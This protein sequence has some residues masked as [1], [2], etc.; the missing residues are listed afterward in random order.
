MVPLPNFTITDKDAIRRYGR[1]QQRADLDELEDRPLPHVNLAGAN[2]PSNISSWFNGKSGKVLLVDFWG[3]WCKPCREL[4]PKLKTLHEKYH[5]QGL[6]ILGVHTTNGAEKMADYVTAEKITWP[7][8]ADI[9]NETVN[10]WCVTGY[11]SLYLVDRAGKVRFA[12][13]Y[14][15]DLEKA[16][17]QLLAEKA[18]APTDGTAASEA[19]PELAAQK[20]ALETLKEMGVTI[21]SDGPPTEFMKAPYHSAQLWKMPPQAWEHVARL[22]PLEDLAIIGSDARGS[23]LEYLAKLKTLRKLNITNSQCTP[24]DLKHLAGCGE[25]ERLEVNFLGARVAESNESLSEKLGDLTSEEQQRVEQLLETSKKWKVKPQDALRMAQ[26]E[27][28]TDRVVESLSQLEHLRSLTLGNGRITCWGLEHLKDHQA[29]EEINVTVAGPAEHLGLVLKGFPALR[30]FSYGTVSD[31]F[32]A[33]IAGLAHLENLE[34]WANDLT[35]AGVPSLVKL[36]SLQTLAIRGNALTDNGLQ[37]LSKLPRL[38]SLDISYSDNI[39]AAGVEDFQRSCP[40]CKVDFR[41]NAKP[42][43]EAKPRDGSRIVARVGSETIRESDLV[44][45]KFN[46]E[47]KGYEVLGAADEVVEADKDR[48]PPEQL[49]AKR[50]VLKKQILKGI[51]EEKL[52]CQDAKRTIPSEA[53]THIEPQ[54]TKEFENNELPKMMKIA[55]VSTAHEFDEKLRALGSSL[56]HE[57]QAFAERMLAQQWVSQQ[58]KPKEEATVK[59]LQEAQGDIKKQTIQERSDKQVREYLAKLE[60]RTPVWTIFDDDTPKPQIATPP[61]P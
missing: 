13:V 44:L 42:A 41:S 48:I 2:L 39:T 21:Y 25:L 3:T 60:A 52:I 11:P 34:V 16:I 57:K 36:T 61:Q 58:T 45:R 43:V 51:I 24:L 55:G 30:R 49:E 17:V 12:G 15:E 22:A 31:E 10:A 53:W 37:A 46:V 29:M 14:E 32:F 47:K 35:D 56:E 9:D 59:P 6:R 18:P 8:A 4:T 26:I 20:A 33:E 7:V 27:I 28:L 54:L 5:D 50:N 40:G 38:K 23:A 19:S 1:P